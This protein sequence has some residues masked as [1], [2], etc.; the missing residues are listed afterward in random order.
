MG[1]MFAEAIISANMKSIISCHRIPD[2]Y[3][4]FNVIIFISC[5]TEYETPEKKQ[6]L[7]LKRNFRFYLCEHQ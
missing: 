5:A 6:K 7:I 4:N 3:L 1:F 2:E